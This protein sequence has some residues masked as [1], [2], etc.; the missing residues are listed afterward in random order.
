LQRVLGQGLLVGLG[1]DDGFRRV[2]HW[3]RTH[4]S[5]HSGNS[6][7]CRL[8]SFFRIRSGIRTRNAEPAQPLVTSGGGSSEEDPGDDR[9]SRFWHYH[10]PGGLD[11]KVERNSYRSFRVTKALFRMG[12]GTT[13][14]VGS[15]ERRPACVT[16]RLTVRFGLSAPC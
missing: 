7:P 12:T 16:S 5:L 4:N 8:C 14:P 3:C 13:P 10:G 1:I 11:G 15:P 6:P 9:L 2:G